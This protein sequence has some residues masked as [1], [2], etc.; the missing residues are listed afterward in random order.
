MT[1]SI[2]K[3]RSQSRTGT[4]ARTGTNDD[5]TAPAPAPVNTTTDPGRTIGSNDPVPVAVATGRTTLKDPP[6]VAVPVSTGKH[7]PRD[8]DSDS[9]DDAKKPAAKPTKGRPKKVAPKATRKPR[10][11][12]TDPA[13]DLVDPMANI[14]VRDATGV[15]TAGGIARAGGNDPVLADMDYSN[16]EQPED[17]SKKRIRG[18]W[19]LFWDHPTI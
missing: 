4:T 8:C 6:P 10:K 9:N 14:H 17:P 19:L 18:F 16:P 5:T 15:V 7:V 2:I 13:D 11:P 12:R 3:T 1:S